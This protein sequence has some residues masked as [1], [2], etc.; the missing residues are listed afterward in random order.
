MTEPKFYKKGEGLSPGEE[1]SH[2]A[3][4]I[5]ES[6]HA[7]DTFQQVE[8]HAN[9]QKGL[10]I[11]LMG[12]PAIA[13]TLAKIYEKRLE[14]DKTIRQKLVSVEDPARIKAL[15]RR[16]LSDVKRTRYEHAVTMQRSMNT[17]YLQLSMAVAGKRAEQGVTNIAAIVNAEKDILDQLAPKR[18]S[19]R[20]RLHL[21]GSK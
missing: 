19:I 11:P 9:I 17:H 6:L 8:I 3:R 18:P 1:Y 5:A 13:D 14:E 21:G 12:I 4:E 20:E 16:L 15:S 2:T 7:P 10:E